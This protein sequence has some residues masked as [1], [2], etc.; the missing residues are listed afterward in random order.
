[1]LRNRNR[2]RECPS[3]PALAFRSRL[4]FFMDVL[5]GGGYIFR[6]WLFTEFDRWRLF[7]YLFSKF[8]WVC[9]L[10][11]RFSSVVDGDAAMIAMNSINGCSM[12]R[13][14]N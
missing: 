1:M 5:G 9:L 12:E 14:P 8:I 2:N 7:I 3:D 11:A 10:I 6:V 4:D 13:G